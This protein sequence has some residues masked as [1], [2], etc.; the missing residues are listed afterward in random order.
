M[1]THSTQI[2]VSKYHDLDKRSQGSLL[3]EMADSRTR[4]GELQNYSRTSYCIRE[5]VIMGNKGDMATGN[6]SAC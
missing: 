6:K 3:R 1:S 2:L 4:V 5:K